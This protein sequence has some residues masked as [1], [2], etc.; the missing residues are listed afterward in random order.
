VQG[1]TDFWGEYEQLIKE[2]GS[3]VYGPGRG[4]VGSPSTVRDWLLDYEA[5]GIDEIMLFTSPRNHEATMESIELMGKHVIPEFQE[6]DAKAAAAKARR[7]EPMLERA[8]ARR[9]DDGRPPFDPNYRIG[10]TPFSEKSDYVAQEV[11]EI[12]QRIDDQ[13]AASATERRRAGVSFTG[14]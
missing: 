11:I 6:R 3:L 4:C 10:G 14:R 2:D 13:T 12:T 5:C 1:R 8:E 9:V 7:I